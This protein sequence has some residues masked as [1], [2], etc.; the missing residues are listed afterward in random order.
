MAVL[1]PAGRPETTFTLPTLNPTQ[2]TL[3]ETD[4]GK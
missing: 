2:N 1:K 3:K 4:Y